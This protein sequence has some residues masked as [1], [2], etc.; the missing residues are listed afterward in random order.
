MSNTPTLAERLEQAGNSAAQSWVIT[1]LLLNAYPATI[2]QSVI[3][4]AV[5]H[6]FTAEILAALLDLSMAE[7]EERYVS[8]QQLSIVQPFGDL[9]HTLHDLTRNGILAHLVHNAVEELRYYS[10]RVQYYFSQQSVALDSQS[11]VESIY[12]QL[13][14]DA[15]HGRDALKASTRIY[16][17]YGDFAAIENLLRNYQE[18]IRLG[19]LGIEDQVELEQQD[20]WTIA[21]LTHRGKQVKD[22]QSMHYLRKAL[23]QFATPEQLPALLADE[24]EKWREQIDA[25]KRK[26]VIEQIENID[27]VGMPILQALWKAELSNIYR[28]QGDLDAALHLLDEALTLTPENGRIWAYRG[29]IKYQMQRYEEALADLDYAIAL[30]NNDTWAIRVRG[31]T[32][33]LMAQYKKAMVDFER[34]IELDNKDVWAIG[35]RAETYRLMARHEEA[36]ADFDL[37]VELDDKEVWAI[38]GRGY[39]YLLLGHYAES[40]AELTKALSI[41]ESDWY[42]Y[43]RSLSYLVQNQMAMAHSDLTRAIEL[44]NIEYASDPIDWRNILN[45]MLYNLV[46]GNMVAAEKFLREVFDGNVPIS[47]LQY[48]CRDLEELLT[49]L[50]DHTQARIF[51]QRIEA[52]LSD[53]G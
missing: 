32:Y 6:W 22:K 25:Y 31:E 12:H 24:P 30:N 18:L 40:L 20:Y 19:L 53:L 41:E 35:G 46:A 42:F 23:E 48:I 10:Q 52:H 36:L 29:A 5:P 14:L 21:A 47:H 1:E 43:C 49:V 34:V 26:F 7:A 16:R 2:R 28:D 33:R 50:P 11:K 15:N 27:S 8:L 51:L 39:V 9:G 38:G 17:R 4:A 13:I 3:A 45:L 37:I 44:G